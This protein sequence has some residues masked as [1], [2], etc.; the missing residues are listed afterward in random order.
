MNSREIYKGVKG[1]DLNL[2]IRLLLRLPSRS[3]WNRFAVFQIACGDGPETI[4]RLNRAST[5]E[6]FS[7]GLWYAPDDHPRVLIMHGMACITNETGPIIPLRNSKTDP[8]A[9]IAAI[10][11][12][13]SVPNS[14]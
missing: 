5:Q 1:E 13:I 4:T 9:A 3:L 11:H 10:I 12:I 6:H 8:S 14:P 7:I 2:R